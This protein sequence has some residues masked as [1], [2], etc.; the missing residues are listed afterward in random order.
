MTTDAMLVV[1]MPEGLLR[2]DHR[3]RVWANLVARH[4][5]AMVRAADGCPATDVRPAN[6]DPAAG[7]AR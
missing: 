4:P 6:L 5:V 2:G 1:E 7:D 3:D